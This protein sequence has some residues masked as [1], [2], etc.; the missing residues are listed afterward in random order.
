MQRVAPP[1]QN[2][3]CWEPGLDFG[4][5]FQNQTV[6]K[7]SGTSPIFNND[8]QAS[9]PP[10]AE[11][12]D[13][14][15]RP[16]QNPGERFGERFGEGLLRCADRLPGTEILA[17]GP[18]CRT[19]RTQLMAK[20]GTPGHEVRESAALRPEP[21]FHVLGIK[22]HR[23]FGKKYVWKHGADSARRSS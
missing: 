18:K 11:T 22:G 23:L 17:S 1:E 20:K 2:A 3:G 15:R 10:V 19:G 9:F 7:G 8:E 14:G 12:S 21:G 5:A 4:L 13:R 6:S 16:L